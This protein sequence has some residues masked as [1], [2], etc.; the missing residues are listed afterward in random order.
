M[1][2]PRYVARS[3]KVAARMVGDELMIM[4]GRDSTLF[5]LNATAA[6]LWEAAD[7]M[8][9]LEDIVAQRICAAFD[10]EPGPALRDAEDLIRQLAAH[11]LVRLS[12]VPIA[13]EAGSQTTR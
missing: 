10:V 4:S 1:T 9:P 7:G 13:P 11:D 5:A 2:T 6:V 8:T 3:R 12:D